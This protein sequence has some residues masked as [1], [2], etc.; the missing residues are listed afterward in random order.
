MYGW[1]EFR[2]A[3]DGLQFVKHIG[4]RLVI[5][6]SGLDFRCLRLTSVTITV[7][8]KLRERRAQRTHII[9]Q[10]VPSAD[11][12]VRRLTQ[13]HMFLRGQLSQSQVIRSCQVPS[14]TS[15]HLLRIHTHVLVRWSRGGEY[16]S[17]SRLKNLG[18]GNGNGQG[19]TKWR[20]EAQSKR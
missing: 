19:K 15:T 3:L 14:L 13:I 20:R 5:V 18:N 2:R 9:D 12:P 17:D 4:T 10:Q 7:R 11:V 1:M 8:Q 6:T 16:R